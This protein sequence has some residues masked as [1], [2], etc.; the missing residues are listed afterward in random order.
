M[1]AAT[2]N[3]MRFANSILKKSKTISPVAARNLQYLCITVLFRFV[4]FSFLNHYKKLTDMVMTDVN[5]Y[6]KKMDVV[7]PWP[8][9]LP[10]YHRILHDTIGFGDS[11]DPNKIFQEKFGYALYVKILVWV[12]TKSPEWAS[13]SFV[14]TKS[15]KKRKGQFSE[16]VEL[17]LLE[18]RIDVVEQR[19]SIVEALEE[20]LAHLELRDEQRAK[21]IAELEIQ[22]LQKLAIAEKPLSQKVVQTDSKSAPVR[23]V[24][25]MLQA[26]ETVA[27][28]E[29][30]WAGRSVVLPGETN[31][32]VGSSPLE[33]KVTIA[34][35]PS[36]V[37]Q[38]TITMKVPGRS[39]NAPLDPRVD[40]GTIMANSPGKGNTAPSDP[41]V[42]QGTIRATLPGRLKND[43]DDSDNSDDDDDD[44][45][46]ADRESV[47]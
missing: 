40:Q 47:K 26:A 21:Q 33:S 5:E 36:R 4:S 13:E 9:V 29:V 3:K 38:D 30:V 31:K 45:S 27:K 41:R 1:A 19:C 20:R 32:D 10:Y 18:Q 16:P 2:K 15:T 8:A 37:E 43:Q 12:S 44:L 39:K 24:N 34:Q 42:V 7:S 11:S 46:S 17:G 22:L 25:R 23:R 14:K 35:D 6:E 28:S